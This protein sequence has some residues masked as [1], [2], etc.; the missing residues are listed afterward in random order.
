MP[1]RSRTK[2]KKGTKMSPVS[3][4]SDDLLIEIISRVPFKS[5]RCCKCVCR[6]WRDLVSD[7]DNHKKLPR[8]ILAGFFYKNFSTGRAC[9]CYHSL[10]G[11]WGPR[12]DP[13][14]SFLPTSIYTGVE[15]LDCCNGLLLCRP[16]N[17]IWNYVVCNPAAETWVTMHSEWTDGVSEARLGFDPAVSSHFH[18][19]EFAHPLY[20]KMNMGRHIE[21]VR[22][23]SA[24]TG[25]WTRRRPWDQPTAFRGISSSTFL[26]GVLYVSSYDGFVIAAIDLEGNHSVIPYPTPH[27]SGAHVFQSRGK[28]HLANYGPSELSIWALEDSSSET[29]ILKHNTSHLQ[30]FGEKYSLFAQHFSVIVHPEHNMIFILCMKMSSG[31]KSVTKLMSYEMDSRELHFVCDIPYGCTPRYLPYIMV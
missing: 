14:L 12:I 9:R 8:S 28:L 16:W 23:Y 30:L 13:S 11:S 2:Q 18:V 24:E 17:Q 15:V 1:R 10:A 3:E 22:I 19:F 4:L 31:R 7:P 29:W 20:W 26:N 27:T 21:S 5:T 25:V 6:R